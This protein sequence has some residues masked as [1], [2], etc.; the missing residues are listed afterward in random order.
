MST[1][2][3]PR[4]LNIESIVV[5]AVRIVRSQGVAGL[6]M[7][8]VA[9][10]L[11]VTPM[12]IYYY[13]AD[14]DELLGLVVARVSESFGVLRTER[15]RTWQETLR[16]YMIRV[17]QNFR[18]YPGLS[19]YLIDQPSLGVTADRLAAGIA[20]FEDAGFP[21][22]QAPLAWS[23]ATTYI[24]GRISVD[25]HVGRGADT[26]HLGGLKARDFVAFGVEAVIAGLEAM[27]E[28]HVPL[29]SAELADAVE[30]SPAPAVPSDS[31]YDGPVDAGSGTVGESA[32]DLT[33][34]ATE[35]E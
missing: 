21:A 7:R 3:R 29:V 30:S 9:T 13:V 16:Q 17:W 20:F 4:S 15:G 11:G 12:A 27:L 5:E 14:K 28:R 1:S 19:S 22:A 2:R 18:W 32:R 26:Q 8:S 33:L 25:A 31:R 6:T 24:H 23:F 34:A 10:G 35:Q